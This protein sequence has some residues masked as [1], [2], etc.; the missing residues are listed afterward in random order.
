MAGGVPA[1]EAEIPLHRHR[2]SS[3]SVSSLAAS[4]SS[5]RGSNITLGRGPPPPTAD[6]LCRVTLDGMWPEWKAKEAWARRQGNLRRAGDYLV[7]H[8]DKDD[9]FWTPRFEQAADEDSSPPP[10]PPRDDGMV[11]RSRGV[12]QG[13]VREPFACGLCTFENP[14]GAT[15]CGMCGA[16]APAPAPAPAA[17]RDGT[18]F[19]EPRTPAPAPAPAPVTNRTPDGRVLPEGWE[20][21]YDET[22]AV[23]YQD[24]NTQTTHWQPP[25]PPV[26]PHSP[27]A[28][29]GSASSSRRVGRCDRLQE[30]KIPPQ[31]F[32]IDLSPTATGELSHMLFQLLMQ[33][34]I[35]SSNGRVFHRRPEDIFI[36]EH[37]APAAQVVPTLDWLIM[38]QPL[39]P[40]QSIEA[41]KVAPRL[42]EDYHR[43]LYYF[44][45][46]RDAGQGFTGREHPDVEC[47][48]NII[49]ETTIVD[50][51]WQQLTAFVSFMN[52]FLEA[53]EVNPFCGPMVQDDLP[54]FAKFVVE[55]LKVGARDFSLPTLGVGGDASPGGRR[56]G[57]DDDGGD[58]ID[59]YRVRRKWE[60]EDHPYVSFLSGGGFD[61]FGFHVDQNGHH[62]DPLT[63]TVKQQNVMPAAL[64]QTLYLGYG[65]QTP[66]EQGQLVTIKPMQADY[67]NTAVWDQAI[68]RRKLFRIM[69]LETEKIQVIGGEAHQVPIPLDASGSKEGKRMQEYILTPD[70]I[71][72]IL[73]I[74]YRFKVGIPVALCGH[75]GCGK[76]ALVQF[77][78]DAMAH[79]W[80]PDSD[81]HTYAERMVIL[82]VHGGTT[83]AEIR[84]AVH[85]TIDLAVGNSLLVRQRSS[86]SALYTVLFFDEV[87]TCDHQGYIKSLV[88]DNLLDGEPIDESLNLRFICALNPYE[89]HTEAMIT[90]LESA[91]LGYSVG[92]AGA[93]EKI[94]ATPMR[95]LVYRVQQLPKSLRQCV[96]DFGTLARDIEDTYI[97]EMVGTELTRFIG[98]DSSA[99]R[100]PAQRYG[101]QSRRQPRP[102]QPG[103]AACPAG[104]ELLAFSAP[105]SNFT[106][107]MC[108]L[109]QANGNQLNGCRACD[110]DLCQTCF[111]AAPPHGLPMVAAPPVA[112]APAPA[113][114]AGLQ[115]AA[116]FD[117]PAVTALFSHCLSESQKI[118]RELGDE[119]SFVSL[120]DIERALKVFCWFYEKRKLLQLE[121]DEP[122][123][124]DGTGTIH[125][126]TKC[127]ILSLSVC[128]YSKLEAQ[129][130]PYRRRLAQWLSGPQPVQPAAGG[131]A[132]P[133]NVCALC[134]ANPVAPG[135]PFCG[136]GCSTAA[137]AQGYGADGTPPGGA[138]PAA[139]AIALGAA[140]A[141][142]A[143]PANP[144][145][146][147][148][149]NGP[150]QIQAVIKKCQKLIGA[151][152]QP[153]LPEAVALNDALCENCFLMVVAIETRTPLFL[154]GKPGSSKSLAKNA[155]C[156]AMHGAGSKHELF[157]QLKHVTAF[158]YQCSPLSRSEEIKKVFKRAQLFQ[159]Q[160][161]D[162]NAVSVVVLDE[163]G[164][165]EDSEYMPLKVLHSLLEPADAGKS[166][167]FI[168][169]SNWALDPAKMNRG[170]HVN[171]S[172]PGLQ[173]L[174]DS[175]LGIC[176]A[177]PRVRPFV[178][179][180]AEAYSKVYDETAAGNY[181]DFFGL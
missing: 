59:A 48:T 52:R 62:V 108:G 87:N 120:R 23:Y 103:A 92:T 134:R 27:A 71:K 177:N 150:D 157:K 33:S 152:L 35:R 8:A 54:G 102:A 132:A 109:A 125:P 68:L 122:A 127:I 9:A 83:K 116:D 84:A 81:E 16:P 179:K 61:F 57:G 139:A 155:V 169:I 146:L 28:P 165:A 135:N 73:A 51:T 43:V 80:N 41:G 106:C 89:K 151:A 123:A 10:P 1:G 180:L 137:I 56:G 49:A 30:T 86:G 97:R 53:Y 126:V 117:I 69:N 91:G 88:C 171:R 112:V 66:N 175:A 141:G 20:I 85:K 160:K 144:L 11:Q 32:V 119:C 40:Q 15:A 21:R 50:P 101:R 3:S 2:G 115:A 19:A 34:E 168:G 12:V 60:S 47:L 153:T 42:P 149:P 181:S 118:M 128:Y 133:L 94:G 29:A 145:L 113:V 13:V 46:L 129:R 163:I 140:M 37:T 24:N 110:H 90:K 64:A 130:E 77:M 93:K 166:V 55:F 105:N 142:G 95:H 148:G 5:L 164:L 176:K 147:Q 162:Q 154:V 75:T 121:T 18:P 143:A 31:L 65:S 79:N 178:N 39:S 96:W 4:T 173:D 172:T 26:A 63:G 70:N 156:D 114:P 131:G 44:S 78:C 36:V 107:N 174:V 14:A 6:E 136:R 158:S 170:I 111:A 74:M 45:A 138:G 99:L 104:H 22:G 159:D 67:H 25:P 38:Q 76:T 98:G 58:E 17:P 124:E 7:T 161:A 72:K 100:T 167:A 82:K